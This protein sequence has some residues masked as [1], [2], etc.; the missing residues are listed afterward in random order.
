[1]TLHAMYNYVY[2]SLALCHI[3]SL[4][5]HDEGRSKVQISFLFLF[6]VFPQ[7]IAHFH[8]SSA[9]LIRFVWN[10]ILCAMP[11]LIVRTF[12]TRRIAVLLVLLFMYFIEHFSYFKRLGKYLIR[13]GSEEEE[14]MYLFWIILALSENGGDYAY[15]VTKSMSFTNYFTS[16]VPLKISCAKYVC[17]RNV[18]ICNI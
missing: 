11:W 3:C 5:E 14:K 16:Y 1:M 10:Q 8:K 12:R 18:G 13:G 9:K 4:Y 17:P 7:W 6:L 15:V 2:E